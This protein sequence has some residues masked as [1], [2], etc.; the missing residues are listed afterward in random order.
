VTSNGLGLG[1]PDG[2]ENLQQFRRVARLL[3]EEKALLPTLLDLLREVPC[4]GTTI[5]DALLVATMQ[6]HKVKLLVTSNQKHF[7]RFDG[8]IEVRPPA[9]A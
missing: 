7:E 5:H 8:L 6:A 9:A 3:P 1:L 2:L 4:H